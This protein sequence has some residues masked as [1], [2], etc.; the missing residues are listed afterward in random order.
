VVKTIGLNITNARFTMVGNWSPGINHLNS[1]LV[2]N[3]SNQAEAITVD[4]VMSNTHP[5]VIAAPSTFAIAPHAH[6]VVSEALVIP[7]TATYSGS[8]AVKTYFAAH[9]LRTFAT[10]SNETVAVQQTITL[11][12]N[13]VSFIKPITPSWLF[14]NTLGYVELVAL[15]AVI[16]ILLIDAIEK[17]KKK[18]E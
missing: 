13:H 11:H 3:T 7:N 1:V 4:P 10:H 2:T 15:S 9:P 18:K 8:V 14:F 12:G 17:R 5:F 6:Q 16:I